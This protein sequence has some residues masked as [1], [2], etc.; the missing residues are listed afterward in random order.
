MGFEPATFQF[1]FSSKH[2]GHLPRLWEPTSLRGSWCLAS[3]LTENLCRIWNRIIPSVKTIVFN[4]TSFM[5]LRKVIYFK[6]VHIFI[7]LH[8]SIKQFLILPKSQKLLTFTK[9]KI[10]LNSHYSKLKLFTLENTG[11]I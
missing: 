1:K 2:T 3:T 11:A 10:F 7:L 4:E 6:I 8:F 9:L 5:S